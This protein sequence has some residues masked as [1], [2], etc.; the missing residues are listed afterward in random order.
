[1]NA[2]QTMYT[3]TFLNKSQEDLTP[4]VWVCKDRDA[5]DR[6]IAKLTGLPHIKIV[7]DGPSH[8]EE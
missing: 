7:Q 1:M 5:F 3:V 6:A 8:F 2:F 4:T